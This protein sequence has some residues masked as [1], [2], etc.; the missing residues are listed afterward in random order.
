MPGRVAIVAGAA[1]ESQATIVI[2]RKYMWSG[3]AFSAIRI[4]VNRSQYRSL[5]PDGVGRVSFSLENH[6]VFSSFTDRRADE[7]TSLPL[8]A[9][10]DE[11]G[12]MRNSLERP[13]SRGCFFYLQ[14][15][16]NQ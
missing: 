8:L 16:Q 11:A 4:A 9:L 2:P 15:T 12:S 1:K 6:G 5:P 13:F 10:S 3:S 14:L 7:L